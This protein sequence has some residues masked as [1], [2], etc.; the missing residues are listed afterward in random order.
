MTTS[1]PGAQ[2]SEEASVPGLQ[3]VRIFAGAGGQALG[4]ERAGF[5]HEP[6]VELD[7]DACA[8]LRANRDSW[9]TAEGDVASDIWTPSKYEG[10]ALL[11]GGVQYHSFVVGSRPRSG[12]T[13]QKQLST[14]T[15]TFRAVNT[16]SGRTR[17]SSGRSSRRALR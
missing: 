13:C 4:L 14:N 16:I 15:P 2:A 5:E 1:P 17:T 3:V 9:D 11:A 10:I 12:Q 6:A 8:T 7:S